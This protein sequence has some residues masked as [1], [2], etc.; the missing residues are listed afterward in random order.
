MLP[1][2]SQPIPPRAWHAAC[3]LSP[4]W[5]DTDTQK[6][7]L[8]FTNTVMVTLPPAA[9]TTLSHWFATCGGGHE[10]LWSHDDAT[11][12]A[13][14]GYRQQ[15]AGDGA[16]AAAAAAAGGTAASAAGATE[17]HVSLPCMVIQRLV[18][19]LQ[20]Y[21]TVRLYQGRTMMSELTS[22]VELLGLAFAANEEYA[23]VHGA[24]A[25]LPLAA[26]YNEVVSSE[27]SLQDDYRRW[28]AQR[29][30][31]AGGTSGVP[32]FS[33]CAHPYILDPAAKSTVLATDAEVQQSEHARSAMLAGLFS[34]LHGGGGPG[35]VSPYFVLRIRRDH[36]LEDALSG[37]VTHAPGAAGAAAAG[38]GGPVS[39][40][41]ML[42][43][44][45]KVQF[46]GEDGI[47]AGGVRREFFNLMVRQ[48]FSPDFGMFTQEASGPTRALWFNGES[49]E[50]PVQFELVG[51]LLGLAIYNAVIL[52]IH[53]PRVLYRKLLAASKEASAA[54]EAATA[55]SASSPGPFMLGGGGGDGAAAALANPLAMLLG[56]PMGGAGTGGS[57]ALSR[58]TSTSSTGGGSSATA[59][60][61][62]SSWFSVSITDLDDFRPDLGATLRKVLDY[63]GECLRS[64]GPLVVGALATMPLC[65]S[66]TPHRSAPP[67]VLFSLQATTSRM[68]CAS[69]SPSPSRAGAP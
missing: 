60:A 40:S 42:K 11:A 25:A 13:L 18:D 68:R 28:L 51:A 63:E 65:V 61:P 53:F 34:T 21:I 27:I 39:R 24:A 16:A 58:S 56:L 69:T 38:G 31:R 9:R 62:P 17:H 67:T 37:I 50:A 3:S 12:L 36:M 29:Q 2:S 59:R 23:L 32:P 54:A 52:D 1:S 15:K 10:A 26:F 45:L 55:A 41:S 57:P 22:P 19:W 35:E 46:A 5:E 14:A 20:Q 8:A 47:D 6:H 43:R 66:V 33:F 44:P 49:L 4:L 48:L 64:L 30:G 7:L